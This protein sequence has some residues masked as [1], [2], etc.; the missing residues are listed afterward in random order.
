MERVREGT[1]TIVAP[2]HGCGGGSVPKLEDPPVVGQQAARVAAAVV[3]AGQ[4]DL[5]LLA[6]IGAGAGHDA[7]RGG[8]GADE[9]AAG[10]LRVGHHADLRVVRDLPVRKME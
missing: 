9:E 2:D 7:V 1:T 8:A 5:G 10:P 6:G 4:A 3:P